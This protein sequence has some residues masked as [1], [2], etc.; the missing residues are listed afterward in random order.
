M[1]RL[2]F[3]ALFWAAAAPLALREAAAAPG[4]MVIDT[5]PHEHDRSSGP[6]RWRQSRRHAC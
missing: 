1:R 2:Q 6:Q 5:C 3:V 4:T